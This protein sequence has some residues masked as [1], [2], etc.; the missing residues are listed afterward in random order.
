M[1]TFVRHEV[2]SDLSDLGSALTRLDE[3]SVQEADSILIYLKGPQWME[4]SAQGLPL[5]T[6][7]DVARH[8]AMERLAG[9]ALFF[10][11]DPEWLCGRGVNT[12]RA[13]SYKPL[14]FQYEVAEG[15]PFSALSE[16]DLQALVAQAMHAAIEDG[17][18]R[19]IVH[20]PAGQ[21]FELPSK[22]HASHFIR[23]SEAFDCVEAVQRTAYWVVVSLVAEL[24]HDESL[25]ERRFLVDHPSMLLLG[26][27]VNH[28]YGGM[29][30]VLCLKGYPSEATLRAETSRILVKGPPITAV[31]GIAS[32]G[33]LANV[34][35]ELAE[36]SQIELDICLV[37]AA[38]DLPDD[39]TPLARLS[40]VGYFH[41]SDAASCEHCGQGKPP[42]IRVHGN[43]F[44][45]GIA[46]I[47][48][49]KLQRK[50]FEEQRPF[51]DKY[52]AVPGALRVH[53]DDPNEAYPRHHA[54]GIDATVL[55]RTPEF[56]DEVIQKLQ[57]LDPQ[58]DFVVIANHKASDLL[59]ETIKK[60]RDL[61]VVFQDQLDE[62][63]NLARKPTVLVFDDKIVSGDR[64]RNLNVRLRT[65][66]PHLWDTFNHVHFF[67]PIVTTKSKKQLEEVKS[68]LTT[69]HDWG[70]TLHHLY[71][72]HLPDWHTPT[73]CPWCHEKRW[74]ERLASGSGKLDSPLIARLAQLSN[75]EQLDPMEHL[76]W[77]PGGAPF[78]PLGAGSVAGKAGS[79]QL[80]VL[81]A[82]ASAVQQ[83]R[84][85]EGTVL[86]PYSLTKPTR[87]ACFV[88]RDA[89]TEK[90]IACS[91]LR[92][93]TSD[94]V[95]VEMGKYLV[96]AIQ[97]PPLDEDA[98]L[99]H[100]ELAMA[101]IAGKMGAEKDIAAAW[102]KLVAYG[103]SEQSLIDMGFLTPP[104]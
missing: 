86:D 72:V 66:R 27:H 94:E 82:T 9:R 19:C 89:Y 8:Q 84:T 57:S 51:L 1:K 36:A 4:A 40:V 61:P 101:L 88:F 30:Q 77:L 47:K 87:L 25:P 28:I 96:K 42:P 95:S 56:H 50:F 29:H 35:T 85:G 49:V 100:V 22:A 62:L 34:L 93:L 31:I 83:L 45:I 78:P 73:D 98:N 7:I 67:A 69:N 59:R 32:T 44:L 2:L 18:P 17:L 33:K 15:A 74:L 68:G 41:S 20:A 52:G 102:A 60:W 103:I 6:A 90:L 55:L 3:R 13:G 79:S 64:M 104:Q 70:A 12:L 39:L 76:T 54:F 80:Q 92:S 10:A 91:I 58:P 43:S 97:T 75:G 37:F 11:P 23:L 21:H 14:R 65:P 99:Y 46:E 81:V 16:Q 63:Q 5:D 53:F 38:T 26:T 48:E 24:A 71:C